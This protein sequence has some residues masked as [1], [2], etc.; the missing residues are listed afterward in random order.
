MQ[1][2]II[3]NL[4]KFTLH[5]LFLICTE[6]SFCYFKRLQLQVVNLINTLR[7]PTQLNLRL[8]NRI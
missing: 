5:K 4:L 7:F 2:N 3:V 6:I 1:A 8:Y